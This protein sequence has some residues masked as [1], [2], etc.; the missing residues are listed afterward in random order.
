KLPHLMEPGC[1]FES[2][3]LAFSLW[4]LAYT[5]ETQLPR[6]R[7]IDLSGMDLRR[8]T[9]AGA[10]DRQF[11]LERSVWDGAQLH[12]TEFRD[13]DL[14]GADFSRAEA[15]MSRWL[16][17]RVNNAIFDQANLTGTLWRN[18]TIP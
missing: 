14:S 8:E 3:R 10:H 13:V 11:P 7:I 15:P 17:C 1:S 4:R 2:R 9:F 5:T 18:C 6:A 12:Q 16:S